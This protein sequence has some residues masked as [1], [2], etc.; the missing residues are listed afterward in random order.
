MGM[1]GKLNTHSHVTNIHR[2][3]Q[4][5]KHGELNIKLPP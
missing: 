4:L 5:G 3:N 2:E 1:Y